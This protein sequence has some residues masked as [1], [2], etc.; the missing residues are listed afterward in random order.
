MGNGSHAFAIVSYK[1]L[2]RD[3]TMKVRAFPGKC[4]TNLKSEYKSVIIWR[5][6]SIQKLQV[7]TDAMDSLCPLR[8]SEA[9][10]ITRLEGAAAFPSQVI[11]SLE[12][13]GLP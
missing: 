8:L 4:R 11:K 6:L 7:P 12:G 3:L 5:L 1:P 10:Y 13:S 2:T 9:A